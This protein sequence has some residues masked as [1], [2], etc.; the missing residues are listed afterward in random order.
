MK[1]SKEYREGFAVGLKIA[2]CAHNGTMNQ[3]QR[4][5][6]ILC[7]YMGVL[8]ATKASDWRRGRLDGDT[9]YWSDKPK[10]E[11]YGITI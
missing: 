8:E 4:K 11:P 2:K 3:R 7:P 1:R 6:A 5:I 10:M 9:Q